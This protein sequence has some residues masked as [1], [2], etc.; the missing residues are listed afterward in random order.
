[1]RILKFFGAVLLVFLA[2]IFTLPLVMSDQAEVSRSI[3]IDADIRT[4]F[5]QVNSLQNWASWSPFE[6]GDTNMVSTYS[7]PEQG[8][9][10]RHEWI[11][12]EMGSGSLEI[13][14]SEAYRFIQGQLDMKDG[15]TALDVWHFEMVGDSVEV[16]WTLKMS[17]LK[18]PFHRY[19]G[20]FIESLMSPMQEKGLQKLKEVAESLPK[21][22]PATTIEIESQPSIGIEAEALM[23]DLGTVMQD[24]INELN[25]FM[26]RSRLTP[27]GPMFSMYY[28]WE[29][30]QPIRFTV[31][32]PIEE[33]V[34]ESGKVKFFVREGGK[35]V[36]TINNGPYENAAAAYYEAEAFIADHGYVQRDLP[37]W[38][39]YVKGPA[40]G[41][42][43]KDFITHIHYYI[44]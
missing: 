7:G 22:V 35:L 27:S 10:N 5:R 25:A 4:V 1:M 41:V 39:I 3:K 24:A 14:Q 42:E 37:V 19:F 23:A 20:Y 31:A 13:Q 9:G 38:E 30:D 34:R 33:E 29:Q 6:L 8:V 11:S 28:N 15:G 17:D 40:D 36:Q 16:V 18:Y 43:A 44:Q 21:P 12:E 32:Y 2:V 26:K